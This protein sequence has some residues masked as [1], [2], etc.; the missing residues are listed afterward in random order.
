MLG[1]NNMTLEQFKKTIEQK[2]LEQDKYNA[3][4]PYRTSAIH[5]IEEIIEPLLGARGDSK[6]LNGEEYYSVED[7][8]VNLLE[9]Y[10][11]QNRSGSVAYCKGNK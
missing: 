5:I 4:H 7:S 10:L 8:I 11:N 3:D 1:N 6:G 9:S 2:S